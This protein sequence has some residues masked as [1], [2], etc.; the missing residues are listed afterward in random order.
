MNITRPTAAPANEPRAQSRRGMRRMA[1]GMA[2]AIGLAGVAL[3]PYTASANSGDSMIVGHDN[4]AS[5]GTQVKWNG[6]TGF[7]GVMLLANDS[8]F[9]NSGALFPAAAGG[10]A[11]GGPAGVANGVF[12]YTSASPTS[13]VTPNGV[14]GYATQGTGVLGQTQSNSIF[15]LGVSG[16]SPSGI[17]VSGTSTNNIGVAGKGGL[18]G[19][20]GTGTGSNSRGVEGSGTSYGVFGT[21]TGPSGFGV[22]GSGFIGVTGSSS[23]ISGTGTQGLA[24]GAGGVGVAGNSSGSGGAGVLG[25]ASG[26]GDGVLGRSVN[27][28]LPGNGVH[29]VANGVTPTSGAFGALFAEGGNSNGVYATS[30]STTNAAVTARNAA[31]PAL[32]V[33]G[34]LQVV[35]RAIGQ[36][37]LAAGATSLTVSTSAATANSTILLTPLG[38]P[39]GWLWISA[40]AAGSF[41]IQVSGRAPAAVPVQY[42]IIN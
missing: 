30:T 29:A 11:G 37:T 25:L 13:S 14:V 22:S 12:G 41:T 32:R 20:V 31:G 17:G 4:F 24:F 35:G 26:G 34:T 23:A 36:A 38:N 2:A 5:S 1:L 15:S 27:T 33:D 3:G 28:S 39:G 10:G 18:K 9:S 16:I 42:L 19:V 7:T 21:G 6:A 8:G 40:R